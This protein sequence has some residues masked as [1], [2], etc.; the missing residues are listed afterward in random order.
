MILKNVKLYWSKLDINNPDMGF[1]GNT[2]QLVT[3]AVMDK[4]TAE[5]AKKA[6]VNV[7]VGEDKDGNVER[8]AH[9]KKP[10]VKR[11]GTPN[12]GVPVVGADLMPIADLSSIG[13]GS[14]ANV[15]LFLG[16]YTYNGRSGISVRLNAIQITDLIIFEGKSGSDILDGFEVL[17]EASPSVA[18]AA[19]DVY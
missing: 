7:K 3:K 1:D 16:E 17:A 12:K 2:P 14:T 19:D 13:N 9:L 5:A 10:A 11:D 6:G 4:E 15:K 8:F 18:E